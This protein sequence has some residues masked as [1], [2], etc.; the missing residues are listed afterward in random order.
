MI[1]WLVNWLA[2]DEDGHYSRSAAMFYGLLFWF[3][4]PIIAVAVGLG[5]GF[6][7]WGGS[8]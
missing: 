5:I 7:I 3:T 6:W 1:T 4:L 8:C 2:V